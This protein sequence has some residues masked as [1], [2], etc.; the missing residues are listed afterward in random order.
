MWYII[1]IIKYSKVISIQTKQGFH[2]SVSVEQNFTDFLKAGLSDD[3]L[4][5]DINRKIKNSVIDNTNVCDLK[6]DIEDS[7]EGGEDMD[8]SSNNGVE[9]EGEIIQKKLPLKFQPVLGISSI[10]WNF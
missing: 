2:T 5:L 10:Y 7:V 6:A 8:V 4:R 9:R 3:L 1:I